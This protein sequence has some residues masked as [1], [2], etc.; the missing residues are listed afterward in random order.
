MNNPIK[1]PARDKAIAEI[2]KIDQSFGTI[3]ESL[4]KLKTFELQ[5][6]AFLTM[7]DLSNIDKQIEKCLSDFESYKKENYKPSQLRQTE[8]PE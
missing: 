3:K 8:S 5:R 4:S 2:K 7:A 1:F 6:K